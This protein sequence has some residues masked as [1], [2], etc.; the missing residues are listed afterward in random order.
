MG[1]GGGVVNNIIMSRG[2]GRCGICSEL[3][4]SIIGIRIQDEHIFIYFFL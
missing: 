3:A 2:Q 4:E 1:G